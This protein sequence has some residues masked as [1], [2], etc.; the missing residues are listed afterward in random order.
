MPAES[1]PSPAQPVQPAQAIQAGRIKELEAALAARDEQLKTLLV[2][3]VI[4]NSVFLR[5]K[6]V[7]PPSIAMEVFGRIFTVE[8]VDG[9]ATA[10]A[11][12]PDGSAIMSREDP[13]RLAGPEEALELYI[14]QYYPER[15][16]ILR[17][18]HAGS[19]AAGN[20]ERQSRAGMIIPRNDAKAFAANLE[21]IAR[22][23]VNVR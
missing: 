4:L 23:E 20:A 15:D 19:G 16:A 18:S 21:A 8:E 2:S 13:A 7:L 17:A 3:N 9:V 10:V 5:E 6:T 14:M 1:L 12:A 22:G 11:H